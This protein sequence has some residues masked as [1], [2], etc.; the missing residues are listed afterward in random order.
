MSQIG[1][2]IKKLRKVKG[3]SQQAFA[4]LFNLTRGNISSY[5]ELRA[6]P[7]IEVA[8]EIAKYFS[9]P[10]SELLEKQLT[11]NEILNFEGYTVI[12]TFNKPSKYFAN[13]PLI[14]REIFEE[15]KSIYPRIAELPQVQMPG[16]N[17]DHFIAVE[18]THLIPKPSEFPFE[19]NSILFF[20][21]VRI[22]IL[23]NLHKHFGFFM[24][25]EEL[26]FG[27]Y[28]VDGKKITLTL[29]E[30]KK[31]SFSPDLEKHF[32]VLYAKFERVF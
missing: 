9:I 28:K 31:K 7:K 4:E 26:F 23:H 2:N 11:V 22:E 10:L 3:L 30:W 16:L 21:Q 8:I 14:S 24:N 15:G 1:S 6:E 32:W 29:N 12:E 13:I 5:E 18:N 27:K 25:E 17:P 19:E 20:E